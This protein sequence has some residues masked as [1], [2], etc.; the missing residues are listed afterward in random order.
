M[1]GTKPAAI[2]VLLGWLVHDAQAHRA[3]DWK[4]CAAGT[5]HNSYTITSLPSIMLIKLTL[6]CIQFSASVLARS[7]EHPHLRRRA[8]VAIGARTPTRDRTIMDRTATK[9]IG[10]RSRTLDRR[11]WT[12]TCVTLL[13]RAG[14]VLRRNVA[15]AGP[16]QTLNAFGGM[17]IEAKTTPH[18]NRLV[19]VVATAANCGERASRLHNAAG[20]KVD[21]ALYELEQLRLELEE[22]VAPHLL[23]RTRTIPRESGTFKPGEI[24]Q[25]QAHVRPPSEAADVTVDQARAIRPAA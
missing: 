12:D 24:D 18:L 13:E 4:K 22:V 8:N 9:H 25:A 16:Q 2:A 7:C 19:D 10:P 3:E 6:L 21:S 17:A 23:G 5:Q 11:S 1:A 20:L 14:A 15:P